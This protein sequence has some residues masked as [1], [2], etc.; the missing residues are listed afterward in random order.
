MIKFGITERGDIA[1]DNN[2]IQKLQNNEVQAAILISKG[3]PD[4]QGAEAMQK[5][6]NKII[7]H[8]TTTGYGGTIIGP[9][10][11]PYQKRLKKLKDFCDKYTFPLEH[12]VI[13]VDPI[14]PTEKGIKRAQNVI[15][16][17]QQYGFKRYRFSFIDI[18]RHVAERF[19]KANLPVPPDIKQVN[20][21][22]IN[23]FYQFLDIK[24]MEQLKFESCAEQ[25]KYTEGCISPKDFALCGLNPE[26]CT[27]KSSQRPTCLCCANKTELL[28]RKHR[29]PH[30]CLYCY[31]I[32]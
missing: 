8:A 28:T 7:F 9:N 5:M 32:D 10:V 25:N 23:N 19:K 13:R 2:W 18:Y 14:I 6:K 20:P 27:G 17:A 11:M 24:S 26:D 16:E 1:F 12:I 22:I 21:A 29:C 15:L 30:Q 3:L 31:W 4:Q